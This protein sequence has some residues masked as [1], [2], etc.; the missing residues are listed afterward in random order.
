M[1]PNKALESIKEDIQI[2]KFKEES[3]ADCVRIEVLETAASAIEKQI[4][5]KPGGNRFVGKC[6]CGCTVYPHM[7][8]C[9]KC[10]Q[11]L[12]WR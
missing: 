6:I 11:R 3:H 2:A 1:E 8:Y 12:D 5:V 9:D 10:G 4:A 7:A